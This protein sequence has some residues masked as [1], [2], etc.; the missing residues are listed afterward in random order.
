[1]SFSVL[2]DSSWSKGPTQ[3]QHKKNGDGKLSQTPQFAII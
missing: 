3:Q 2:L 1:M